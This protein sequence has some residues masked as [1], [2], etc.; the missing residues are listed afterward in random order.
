[1]PAQFSI[2]QMTK[3]T[4]QNVNVRSEL[5]GDEHVPAADLSIKMSTSNLVLS[6]FD[7][8]LRGMLYQKPKGEAAQAQLEGVEPVTDMPMLRCTTLEQPLKLKSEY[9]G[10]TLTIDRGLGGGSNIVVGD[11]AQSTR[12]EP[13][14]RKA[15]PWT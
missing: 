15:A 3:V 7:G 5:H 11:C 1:M 12:S 10:Y 4:I 9:A 6:E 8:A 13:T 14:A 2:D